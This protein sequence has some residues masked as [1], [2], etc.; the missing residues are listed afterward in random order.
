MIKTY[1]KVTNLYDVVRGHNN[2]R[3]SF[4]RYIQIEYLEQIIQSANERLR[5]MSNG[6]FELIR[7]DRQEVRGRQSGLGLMSMMRIRAKP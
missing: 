3:L 7:S 2:L 1:G 6:Q 4:E 5:E